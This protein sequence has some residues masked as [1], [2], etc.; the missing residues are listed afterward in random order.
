MV[1]KRK[2][3]PYKQGAPPL[4]ARAGSAIPLNLAAVHFGQQTDV[5]GFQLFPLETGPFEAE[6]FED[7]GLSQSYRQG[8]DGVWSL[9]VHCS[10]E[11]LRVQIRLSGP[12]AA[13]ANEVVILVP[14]TDPHPVDIEGTSLLS[15]PHEGA[16]RHP[17][18][19]LSTTGLIT[20]KNSL[21]PLCNKG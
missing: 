9:A 3:P 18:L 14:Q 19:H 17:T 20:Y 12:T 13:E 6:C 15:E 8:H 1:V 10:A 21:Q 2:W 4:L 16:W 5:R 11:A 7:D